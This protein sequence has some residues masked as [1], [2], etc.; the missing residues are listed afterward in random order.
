MERTYKVFYR[1]VMYREAF[2][3]AKTAKEAKLI[4]KDPKSNYASRF[5]HMF[6]QTVY[7]VRVKEAA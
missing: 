3:N 4:I 1:E 2:V 6:K 5:R 7:A